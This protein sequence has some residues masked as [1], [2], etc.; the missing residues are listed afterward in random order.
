MGFSSPSSSALTVTK[1]TELRKKMIYGQSDSW[2][3]RKCFSLKTKGLSSASTPVFSFRE[4][5]DRF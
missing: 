1:H 3:G 4:D 5:A 2:Q